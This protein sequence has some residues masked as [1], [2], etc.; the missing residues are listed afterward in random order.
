MKARRLAV[1]S[2]RPAARALT[3]LQLL[4]THGGSRLDLLKHLLGAVKVEV[5]AAL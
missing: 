3:R 1:E 5:S 4:G 2:I